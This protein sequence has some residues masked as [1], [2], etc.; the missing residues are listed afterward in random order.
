M[1]FPCSRRLNT[2]NNS[3]FTELCPFGCDKEDNEEHA[4]LN[5]K[6][7]ILKDLKKYILDGLKDEKIKNKMRKF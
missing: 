4:F 3:I 2:W 1:K 6:I 7:C 5:C